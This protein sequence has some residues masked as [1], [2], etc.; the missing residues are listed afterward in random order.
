MSVKDPNFT[1]LSSKDKPMIERSRCMRNIKILQMIVLDHLATFYHYFYH[2]YG[3][4][5]LRNK[6]REGE[7]TKFIVMWLHRDWTHLHPLFPRQLLI[8]VEFLLNELFIIIFF[9][10]T[11]VL[12]THV[13]VRKIP[14]RLMTAP[15]FEI[16]REFQKISRLLLINWWW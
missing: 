3:N 6:L 15:R 11:T 16:E 5:W 12:L 8:S 1:Y 7:S 4:Q 13:G 14:D 10:P 2:P 9:S